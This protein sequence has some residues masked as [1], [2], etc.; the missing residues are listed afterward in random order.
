MRT[1]TRVARSRP[2]RAISWTAAA[3]TIAGGL[4]AISTAGSRAEANTVVQPTAV[5]AAAST[6]TPLW[7]T[8]LDF[9]DNGVPWSEA[10]F[11]ALK[12]DGLTTAEIDMPWNTIEPTQGTFSFTE[13]D[14]ELANA[15]AAGIKLV[16]IFWYAG[17]GGSPAAWVTSH[18]VNSGGAQGTAPAWWDPT[19]EPAYVTYV[20]D[21]VKH[22]AGEAGYGGS[23]LNYGELDSQLNDGNGNAPGR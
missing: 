8:Q 17:W 10:S 13:L 20:T 15:A 12:A 4:I 11:A 22:I 14:Q 2:T 21:T 3:L 6:A 9:D 16:P 18:E 5:T 19:A 7:S 1:R 23:I